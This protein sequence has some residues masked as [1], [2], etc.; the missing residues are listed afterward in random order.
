VTR[1]R[2]FSISVALGRV[3]VG[4]TAVELVSIVMFVWDD[5]FINKILSKTWM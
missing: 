4:V 1:W 3:F 5:N 2:R